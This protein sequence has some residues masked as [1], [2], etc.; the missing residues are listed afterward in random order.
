MAAI[1]KEDPADLS[2]EERKIPTSVE[3][4]VKHCLE[5]NP[6]ER[7]QSARDLAFDL[8]AFSGLSTTSAPAV[9]T[10]I[11]EPRKWLGLNKEVTDDLYGSGSRYVSKQRLEAMLDNEPG[12]RRGHQTSRVRNLSGT[13]RRTTRR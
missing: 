8:D 3:R 13:R 11:S 6:A 2:G 10:T 1:L 12:A 9:A 4:V 7:F 5:K